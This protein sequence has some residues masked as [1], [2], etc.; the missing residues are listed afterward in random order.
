MSAESRQRYPS[1]RKSHRDAAS[2][3]SPLLSEWAR[4]TLMVNG[5]WTDALTTSFNVSI[6]LSTDTP[7]PDALLD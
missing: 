7:G 6:L 3:P 5:E 1:I 4:A 2:K